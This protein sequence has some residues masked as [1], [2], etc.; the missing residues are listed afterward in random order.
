MLS[1]SEKHCKG[2]RSET[3][4]SRRVGG[5]GETGRRP[6]GAGLWSG[7]PGKALFD[8]MVTGQRQPVCV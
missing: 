4:Q 5:G 3:A 6:A 8:W 7:Q 2:N 1:R